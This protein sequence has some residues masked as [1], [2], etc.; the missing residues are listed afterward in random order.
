MISSLRMCGRPSPEQSMKKRIAIL[1]CDSDMVFIPIAGDYRLL[2]ANLLRE[3]SDDLDFDL[4]VYDIVR[5]GEFPTADGSGHDAIVI[6]GSSACFHYQ[7]VMLSLLKRGQNSR[8]M[9]IWNGSMRSLR[10]SPILRCLNRA[11]KYSACVP[12]SNGKWEI[13]LTPVQMT[14]IGRRVFGVP[15]LVCLFCSFFFSRFG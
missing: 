2:I 12:M 5:G 15:V 1:D 10:M 8:R 9:K 7:I 4:D 6:P 11:S 14:D 13:G 3:V